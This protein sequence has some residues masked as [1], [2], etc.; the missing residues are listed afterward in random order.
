[1][2]GSYQMSGSLELVRGPF[3]GAIAELCRALLLPKCTVVAVALLGFGCIQR[4]SRTP[5]QPRPGTN[6]SKA[7]SLARRVILQL[8]RDKDGSRRR[9]LGGQS[10]TR[11]RDLEDC[12]FQLALTE[13]TLAR[14]SRVL[15]HVGEYQFQKSTNSPSSE[16]THATSTSAPAQGC[17]SSPD[18]VR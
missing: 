15:S 14:V 10:F 16:N 13:I 11:C 5:R 18:T 9:D 6:P 3:V 2:Y 8:G 1:M 7:F 17:N 4:L 12:S